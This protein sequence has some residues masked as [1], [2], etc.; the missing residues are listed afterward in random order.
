MTRFITLILLNGFFI[1]T[2]IAQVQPI[3]STPAST[4]TGGNVYGKIID[5]TSSRPIEGA[6]IQFLQNKLDSVSNKRKDFVLSLQVTDKK[7]EFNIQGLPVTGSFMIQVS[8]VGYK[9]YEASVNFEMNTA[10]QAD[11]AS[12]LRSVIKD[13][14]NIKLEET[15]QQLENITVNT[16]KPL[17]EMYVDK[18]VYNVEKDLAA[19]GGTASDVLKNIPSLS[20]DLDG[21]VTMRN[22]APQIFVDGH[23][24]SL[25][26]DQIPAD[27]IAS[28]EII[29]NPSAKY[30]AGGGGAGI[31][32]IILKKNRKAGYNGTL[33][34][35]IDTRGRPILGGDI[36]IQHNKVNFFA[37][38][39][40]FTRKNI[41]TVS[42]TRSEAMP[43]SVNTYQ[44][45]GPV[46]KGYFA[47]GRM[48]AD[49]FIDN[50][51]TLT[52]SGSIVSGNFST[53]DLLNIVK[54]SI[55]PYYTKSESA[56]RN[57]F[58]DISFKNSG[59]TLGFKH[60]FAR[61]GKEWT[62]DANYNESKNSNTSNYSSR[63]YNGYGV[64][65]YSSAER[66][67]GAGH[68][69]FYTLQTDLIYPFSKNI[70]LE[71][72]ARLSGKDYSSWNDNFQQNPATNEYIL[73]PAL[74]VR[75]NFS[76][77]VYAA[78]STFSQQ[79][80]DFSYQLGMRAERSVYSGIL[81]SKN[82]HFSNQFPLSL[83]PSVF[84]SRKLNNTQDLQ[85]NYSRKI[86]RP[87]FFQIL[88]F[89]DFSDSLNL[90]VG[91]PDLNPEFT[92]LAELNYSNQY[93]TG[94]TILTSLYA[95]YT[96]N[97]ITRYQYKAPNTDPSKP[98]SVL[99]NSY[100]NADESYTL[101]LEITGKNKLTEWWEATTNINFFDVTLHAANIPNAKD[102]HLFSWFVKLNNALKIPGNYT[103]QLT[104][105]YQAKTI[106]PVN[107]GRSSGGGVFGGGIFG[108][109]QNI[110]QGY[111]EPLYGVDIAVKKDFLK[112][113]AA[114]VTL[115]VNDIFRT[116][117]YATHA[118]TPYFI[119]D[120]E[121]R[122]DPQVFRL[123]FSW[124]F[125]KVDATL[126]KRKNMKSE[127]ENL[128]NI[129]PGQ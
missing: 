74:D 68:T 60:N 115:Q 122:R 34:A 73:N 41:S 121:R 124:R 6:S 125:G 62:A 86:N 117:K 17:L 30:D 43:D 87:S 67:T 12:L 47:F 56:I 126:F 51:N 50:R 61:A 21:N 19:A 4:V 55:K 5:N 28:I 85:L 71:S 46:A 123:N 20:V 11:M 100:A 93:L 88:P 78:Y 2:G 39:Q 1:F 77:I 99:Y 31:L 26:P 57:I 129:Q 90:T 98:D 24:T 82:E 81:L 7:G 120:N 102:D 52:V 95:K 10:K 22:A 54:D 65:K 91:N 23:P 75:Y 64:P 92:Q 66:A 72:G 69:K 105:D 49:F 9:N 112:N 37:A 114:S 76:D 45:N 58:A 38:G 116:R 59:A 111:I 35:S 29:S 14:G 18:K 48:G 94:H 40:L 106:L 108:T 13:L 103:L 101:G 70:K 8:S 25:S 3:G 104:G 42:T 16:S 80:K 83:F 97:L 53:S 32:N 128:Q 113:K 109:T 36:N 89:V 27:Q 96:N 33:R 63:F 79:I 127:I 110:A 119:Q 118:E 44:E 15:L 107:S 84:I